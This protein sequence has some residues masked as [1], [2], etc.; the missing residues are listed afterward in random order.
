M[1]TIVLSARMDKTFKNGQGLSAKQLRS[2][3]SYLDAEDVYRM[4][5][6]SKNWYDSIMNAEFVEYHNK[7][8]KVN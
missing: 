2:I 1:Y 5:L 6:L 3:L 8:H 7:H 4:R